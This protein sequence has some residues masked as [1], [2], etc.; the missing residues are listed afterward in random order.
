MIRK[1]ELSE[2]DKL[3]DGAEQFFVEGKI[4]GKFDIEI[5]KRNWTFFYEGNFGCIFV[6]IDENEK[7]Y[8]AIG[9]IKVPDLMT[10]TIIASEMFWYVLN[11]HRGE[12]M[13][14]FNAFEKWAKENGCQSIRMIH[15]TGLMVDELKSLYLRRG[16][17]EVETAYEK[18][19][20]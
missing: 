7:V 4:P 8:G 11:G 18:E 20:I 14:L 16:Y 2:L 15:L 1:L 9:C 5:F 12:G 6:L 19:V 3:S 10:A 17:R 13:K